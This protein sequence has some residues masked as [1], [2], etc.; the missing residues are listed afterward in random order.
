MTTDLCEEKKVL[1]YHIFC[2]EYQRICRKCLTGDYDYVTG[3]FAL[4]L[5][6]VMTPV[7][8]LEFQVMEAKISETHQK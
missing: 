6:Y 5:S 2:L 3:L 7:A 8:P 4:S 1:E